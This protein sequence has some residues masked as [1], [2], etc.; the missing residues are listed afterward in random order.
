MIR[1]DSVNESALVFI[2]HAQGPYYYNSIKESAFLKRFDVR[3]KT[4]SWK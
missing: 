1:P 4:I 2:L 3:A